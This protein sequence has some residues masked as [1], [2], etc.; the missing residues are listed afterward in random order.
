[1][2]WD[3]VQ[4][5]HFGAQF[6]TIKLPLLSYSRKFPF[7]GERHRGGKK[8]GFLHIVQELLFVQVAHSGGQSIQSTDSPS[9]LANIPSMQPQIGG[10]IALPIPEEH[11]IQFSTVPEHNLH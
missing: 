9:G 4:A 10:I 11:T 8:K 1:M 7:C 5:S 2:V 3:S 6:P